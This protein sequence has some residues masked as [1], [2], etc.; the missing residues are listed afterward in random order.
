SVFQSL[1]TDSMKQFLSK[2]SSFRTRYYRSDTGKQSQAWLK[3][4]IEAIAKHHPKMTVKDFPHP[5]G[6]NSIIVRFAPSSADMADAPVTIVGAHQ[7]SL[8]LIPFLPSPGADDE[9]SGTTSSIEALRALANANFTPS[10]P[11]EFIYFSAEESGLLGSQAI[12]K[13]YEEEGVK[14]LAMLQMDM[15]AWVKA[16]TEESVGIIQDF[17]DPDLTEFL[18]DLVEKYLSIPPVRTQCGY[19][20]SDHSSFSK[21]GFQSACALESSFE[22][23]NNNIHSAKDTMDHPEFSFNHMREFSKLAVA[24]VVELG[25]FE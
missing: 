5:W 4:Q 13:S 21:A 14:V 10:T 19:S 12:A 20:C 6:Q 24:F 11:V 15:T 18:Y 17:V 25:G 1:N 2:F 22:N 3:S 16:G 7:D 9:G 8:N 23:M